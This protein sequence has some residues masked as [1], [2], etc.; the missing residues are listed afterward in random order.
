MLNMSYC[1]FENTYHA[2]QEC[3]NALEDD[4]NLSESEM[5]YMEKLKDA[6]EEYNELAEEYKKR[7][8]N[9]HGHKPRFVYCDGCGFAGIEI[10][11]EIANCCYHQGQC[12]VDC[13]AWVKEPYI[14]SQLD[15]IPYDKIV[16]SLCEI[17]E[18]HNEIVEASADDNYR[19]FLFIVAS[20][21]LE[22][23]PE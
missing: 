13:A 9:E 3:I 12:D 11:R 18:D 23:Y 21:Y 8:T 22:E 2:L 10:T 15:A 4:D 6:L 20:N 19:R 7:N 5:S 14:K 1:R 17:W 16:Q